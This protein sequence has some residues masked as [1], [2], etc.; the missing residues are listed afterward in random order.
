MINIKDFDSRV[1]FNI[2]KF[3]D[4]ESINSV[5]SLH[6]IIGK[7]DGST[8]GNKYFVFTSTD[9]IKEV[10]AKFAKLWDEI[11]Y[12]IKTINR[13]KKGEYEK[14]FTKI[15]FQSDD[16]LPLNK[17]L[18]LHILTVIVRSVFEEDGNY[19]QVVLDECLYEV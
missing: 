9:S 3:D 1:W 19:L 2:K 15:R 5:N 10:L 6:L 13:S 8:E 11:K 7:V 17:I 14:G 18:K 12:L 4:Y 16:N